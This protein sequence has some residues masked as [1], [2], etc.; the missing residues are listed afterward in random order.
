VSGYTIRPFRQDD[1]PQVEAALAS[2]YKVSRQ[3]C[4]D[5]L[6][7]KYFDNP[8][9]SSPLIVVA[10]HEGIIAGQYTY[11]PM[12]WRHSATG[13]EEVILAPGG[14][15]VLPE[16]RGKGVF[17]RLMSFGREWLEPEYRWFLNTTST[18]NSA[19]A[20]ERFGAFP[21]AK[22]LFLDSCS[23]PGLIHYCIN[24]RKGNASRIR[25]GEHG[26]I[27]V[28][29]SIFPGEM[30][31]IAS[32][33]TS[34][35][36]AVELKRDDVFYAWRYRNPAKKYTF[37]YV[38]RPGEISGYLAVSHNRNNL[39]GY[40]VDY[41]QSDNCS[42]GKILRF[43]KESGHF[44]ILSI[45]EFCVDE[46]LSEALTDGGLEKNRII[47]FLEKRV[48]PFY[49]LYLVKTREGE[50]G[51]FWDGLDLREINNWRIMGAARELD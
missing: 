22:R 8:Y 40:I 28:S 46:G 44:D 6:N 21:L 17:N 2:L 30:S 7:W 35:S 42:L 24:Y 10:E 13:S 37:Y 26:D 15:F 11:T 36:P 38:G 5:F 45:Y 16:Y 33:R 47:R 29:D 27:L 48:T 14:A 20:Y 32:R 41:G 51:W 9:S 31:S 43:L 34:S 4:S 39:R 3:E 23:G 50:S 49:P 12:G 18:R 19:A 1:L 25:Y